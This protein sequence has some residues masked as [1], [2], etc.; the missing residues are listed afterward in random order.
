MK[1]TMDKQMTTLDQ[2][3]PMKEAMKD[4]KARYTDGDLRRVFY[5]FL[6]EIKNYDAATAIGGEIVKC[7][8]SAFPINNFCW[9]GANYAV[10]IT[11]CNFFNGYAFLRF[12]VD[13]DLKMDKRLDLITLREYSECKKHF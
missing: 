3:A 13:Q 9:I 12:Y 5:D 2:V 10:E 11:I 6:D 7:E 4:F 1:I 8:V